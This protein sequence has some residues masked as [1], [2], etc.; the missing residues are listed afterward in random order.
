MQLMKQALYL[1]ATTA[2]SVYS[3]TN[4]QQKSKPGNLEPVLFGV[5]TYSKIVNFWRQKLLFYF[6]AVRRFRHEVV[7]QR[8]SH[9]RRSRRQ[10]L[11]LLLPSDGVVRVPTHC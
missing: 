1:Q 5:K 11:D 4:C 10:E 7:A 9:R 6:S 3:N 2:G 8:R